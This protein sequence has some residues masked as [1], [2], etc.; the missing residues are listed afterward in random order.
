MGEDEGFIAL[1]PGGT[2][3]SPQDVETWGGAGDK[4]GYVGEKVNMGSKVT[5]KMRGF[6]AKGRGEELRVKWG[7]EEKNETVDFWAQR[8]SIFRSTLCD[9]KWAY[10]RISDINISIRFAHI[11][12]IL[13]YLFQ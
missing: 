10:Q 5:P 13:L 7:W 8:V 3:K 2:C 11:T 12:Q 4:E 9:Q 6:S 1:S